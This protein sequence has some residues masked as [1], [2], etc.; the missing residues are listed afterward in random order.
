MSQLFASGGQSIGVS[1]S[2]SV[3]PRQLK[4]SYQNMHTFSKLVF[5]LLFCE[6]HKNPFALNLLFLRGNILFF[7]PILKILFIFSKKYATY[8]YAKHKEG[9]F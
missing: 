8:I 7:Q 6:A 9:L 2:A 4:C 3:L 5:S 1:A